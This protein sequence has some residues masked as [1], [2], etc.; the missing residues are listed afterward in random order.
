MHPQRLRRSEIL[1]TIVDHHRAVG[2]H[3]RH[4]QRA[5]I[6]VA[7]RLPRPKPARAEERGENLVQAKARNAITIELLR[8]VVQR[9]QAKVRSP[10]QRPRDR[11]TLRPRFTEPEHELLECLTSELARNTEHRYVE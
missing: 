8:L 3:L 4:P 5:M 10:S 1:I 7:R 11:H 6:D 9:D 2:I